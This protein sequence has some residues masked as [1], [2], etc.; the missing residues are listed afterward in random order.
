MHDGELVEPAMFASVLLR[1]QVPPP[2][3]VS[4]IVCPTHT[5]EG[6]LIA[7]G[8]AFTV[9]I[10][11]V[12]QPVGSVYTTVTVPV[13]MPVTMPVALST[14]APMLVLLHVPPVLASVSVV[15]RPAHT[16]G[17]PPIVGGVG[18]MVTSVVIAQ[19][20]GGT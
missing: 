10:F 17:V 1:L 14:V 12:A 18:L 9:I 8:S 15:V 2:P 11:E 5:D 7:E 13:L 19:P 16:V 6:P 20:V 3:S 4:V